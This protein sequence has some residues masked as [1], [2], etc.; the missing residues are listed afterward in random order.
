LQ[1]GHFHVSKKHRERNLI[2]EWI[3]FFFTN[4]SAFRMIL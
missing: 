3:R 2:Q 4:G 1:S